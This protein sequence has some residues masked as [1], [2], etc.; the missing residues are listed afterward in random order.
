[1]QLSERKLEE[2]ASRT[3]SARG[4]GQSFPASPQQVASEAGT[5]CPASALERDAVCLSWL[6]C[7]DGVGVGG[8]GTSIHRIQRSEASLI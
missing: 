1:M 7:A 8:A 6:L 4:S 2:S 3:G 5:A